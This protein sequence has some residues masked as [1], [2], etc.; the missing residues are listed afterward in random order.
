[1]K[2]SST[3]FKKIP[4]RELLQLDIT[5]YMCYTKIKR[6]IF[7]KKCEWVIIMTFNQYINRRRKELGM[8]VDELVE[9]SGLPKGTVSKITSGI[10]A[11]PKLTTIEAICRA[12]MCSVDDAMGLAPAASI[13]SYSEIEK[14]N[15]YRSLDKYGKDV[16]D[17]IL[18][19]E[20]ERCYPSQLMITRPYYAVSVSAGYGNPL[21]EP[22]E[23][24]IEIP[25][26]PENR[27]LL[28]DLANDARYHAGKD[29]HGND[30]HFKTLE[31]GSQIWTSSRD[32]IIQEGGL[33]NPPR[34]WNDRTGLN[35]DP[36]GGNHE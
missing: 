5:I 27:K 25:D 6:L 19:I 24:D 22:P 12:L 10:N 35:N 15:K 28:Q 16:M 7:Y 2:L 8:T 34:P 36:F 9:R 4:N 20:Y 33:N 18:D 32:G 13:F 26:T 11:N 21:D 23:E 17:S 31:D 3:F 29:T 30:W 1:M 14:I